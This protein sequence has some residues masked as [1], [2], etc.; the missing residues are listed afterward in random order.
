LIAVDPR[1]SQAS[2]RSAH[3]FLQKNRLKVKVKA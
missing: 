3:W 1:H 2:V